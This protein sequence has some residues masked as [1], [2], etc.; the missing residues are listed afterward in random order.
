MNLKVMGCVLIVLALINLYM[1]VTSGGTS[2]FLNLFAFAFCLT[3]G[4][5][6]LLIW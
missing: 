5:C 4:I 2:R 6:D 1:A 3:V